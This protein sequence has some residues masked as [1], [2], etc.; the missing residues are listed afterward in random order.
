MIQLAWDKARREKR[1]KKRLSEIEW[2]IKKQREQ[3]YW[4]MK[5]KELRDEFEAIWN[6][7]LPVIDEKIQALYDHFGSQRVPRYT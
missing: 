2:E 5:D 6:N 1:E 4:M 7:H 3:K